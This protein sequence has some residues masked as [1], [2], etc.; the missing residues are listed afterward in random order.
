MIALERGFDKVN[1][2]TLALERLVDE[3]GR[4][5]VRADTIEREVFSLLL[6]IGRECLTKYFESAGLGDEGETLEHD[7]KT[8]KRLEEKERTYPF[9]IWRRSSNSLCLCPAREDENVRP[10]WTSNLSYPLSL[11]LSCFRTG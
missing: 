6:E 9:D 8:I 7:N 3:G 10:L 4:E 5:K 1:E 2:L 11:I